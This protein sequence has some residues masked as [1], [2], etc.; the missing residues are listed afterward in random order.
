MLNHNTEVTGPAIGVDVSGYVP[1]QGKPVSIF[2]RFKK[3]NISPMLPMM[4]T[5]YIQPLK[6][7]A[8]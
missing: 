4:F 7:S 1:L 8:F 5:I 3:N 2:Y 6:Y